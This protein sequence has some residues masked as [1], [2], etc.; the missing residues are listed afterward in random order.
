MKLKTTKLTHILITATL[1]LTFSGCASLFGSGHCQPTQNSVSD[2]DF[3]VKTLDYLPSKPS[4][5]TLFIFPPTGG[6]NTID[7]SY[8]SQFCKKGFQVQILEG[9]TKDQETEIDF[10]IHQSFYS[11]AQKAI[12]LVL[13]QS[14]SKFNG[15]IGTSVGGLHASISASLQDRLDAVFV[16]TAG[17]SIAEVV[18][19]SDQEAMKGLNKRRKEKFQTAS[20]EDQIAR[21]GQAFKLEPLTLGDGFKTKDL[22]VSIATKDTVVPVEQQNK[23]KNLWK[24]KKEIYIEND[25]FWG[26]VKTWLFHSDEILDFFEQSA[27]QKLKL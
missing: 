2:G 23:L 10:E 5:K 25:H 20:D 19:Y 17:T 13:N 3:S 12:A 6:T 16:I 11:K 9:W 4:D 21:I 22:G 15:L 18:V 1:A 26:I 27:A 7:K 8:A 14:K 24:P